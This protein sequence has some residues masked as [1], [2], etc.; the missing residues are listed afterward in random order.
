MS[1]GSVWLQFF[2]C[3]AVIAYSGTRLSKYGDVL[4]EKTGLGRSWL[5]LAGLAVVTSLPELI[6]GSSAVLWVGAPD[7]AVGDVMGASLI[8]LMI[9]MVTDLFYPPPPLP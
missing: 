3:L 8:N 1:A 9:V 2:I 4:A 5:G 6:T 7:I